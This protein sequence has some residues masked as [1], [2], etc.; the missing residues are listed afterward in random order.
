MIIIVTMIV[1]H[2][3][4]DDTGRWFGGVV[5]CIDHDAKKNSNSESY[6][7]SSS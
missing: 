6:I 4:W 7:N 2:E 1:I 5:Y 3:I